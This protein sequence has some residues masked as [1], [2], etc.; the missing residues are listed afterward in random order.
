MNTKSLIR[1][2]QHKYDKNNKPTIDRN[3][4][5]HDSYATLLAKNLND[6]IF[7]KLLATNY[8]ITTLLERYNNFTDI[9]KYN[10]QLWNKQLI[11][12]W[13]SLTNYTDMNQNSSI[14]I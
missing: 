4:Y 9:T 3:Y 8:K 12:V 14:K 6:H 5:K 2:L 11:M 1:L 13:A 10:I 7:L